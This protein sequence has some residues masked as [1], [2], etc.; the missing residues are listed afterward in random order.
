LIVETPAARSENR[1]TIR[2]VAELA[3]VSI[4]TVSYVVNDTGHVSLATR[5]RVHAAIGILKWT[6]DPSARS[7]ACLTRESH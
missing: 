7:L 6:P 2:D 4:A 3:G 5:A 1:V